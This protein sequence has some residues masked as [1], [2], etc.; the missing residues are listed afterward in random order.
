MD[1]MPV[2][3]NRSRIRAKPHTFC[4]SKKV[5]VTNEYWFWKKTCFDILVK[6]NGIPLRENHLKRSY[7]RLP[8]LWAE[9]HLILCRQI[10][11]DAAPL[12]RG[13]LF[14]YRCVNTWESDPLDS[15]SSPTM[16]R[17]CEHRHVT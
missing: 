12:P 6:E 4:L 8:C 1:A 3:Q 13:H 2:N 17:C 14:H 16:P 7:Y 11:T 9:S 5:T 10:V 15:N